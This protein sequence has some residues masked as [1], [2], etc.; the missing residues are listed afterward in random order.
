VSPDERPN[1]GVR[2]LTTV[3]QDYLKIIW[4]TQE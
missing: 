4:T 2:E 3:A 1:A